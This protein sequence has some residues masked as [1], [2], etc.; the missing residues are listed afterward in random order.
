[1][2]TAGCTPSA[3]RDPNLPDGCFCSRRGGDEPGC[4]PRIGRGGAHRGRDRKWASGPGQ[5]SPPT[6][7]G[8]PGATGHGSLL[9]QGSGERA[10]GDA[11][12]ADRTRDRT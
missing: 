6:D 10:C 1:V 8:R 2:V 4:T 7:G 9:W 3:R 11:I 5:G 12:G